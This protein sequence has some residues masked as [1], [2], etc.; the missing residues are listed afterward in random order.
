MVVR[1]AQGRN[2]AMPFVYAAAMDENF[3]KQ[4]YAATRSAVAD[5]LKDFVAGL[6]ALCVNALVPTPPKGEG[7]SAPTEA[8]PDTAQDLGPFEKVGEEP[9][10]RVP[11]EEPPE[12]ESLGGGEEPE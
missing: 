5:A 10:P 11:E 3:A 6:F 9:M 4:V 1:D 7:P 12:D 8:A 2:L